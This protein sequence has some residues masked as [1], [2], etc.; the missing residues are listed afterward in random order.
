MSDFVYRSESLF[1]T[2]SSELSF[3]IFSH[4]KLHSNVAK[5]DETRLFFFLKKAMSDFPIYPFYHQLLFEGSLA[6]KQLLR[7][8]DAASENQCLLNSLPCSLVHPHGIVIVQ[9]FLQFFQLSGR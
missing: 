8:N 3:L 1:F 4:A 5:V 7:P 6:N 2:F 9:S